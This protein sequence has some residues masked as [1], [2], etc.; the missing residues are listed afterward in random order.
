MKTNSNIVQKVK[1]TGDFG[2]FSRHKR[3]ISRALFKKHPKYTYRIEDMSSQQIKDANGFSP[4]NTNSE[5][6]LLEHVNGQDL[7]NSNHNTRRVDG[8]LN[9]NYVSTASAKAFIYSGEF[10]GLMT[11]DRYIY[12][13]S[14]EDGNF[15]DVLDYLDK[16]GSNDALRTRR[17]YRSQREWASKGAI[18]YDKIIS[19]IDKQQLIEFLTRTVG[20]QETVKN[21]EDVEK[22]FDS[23]SQPMP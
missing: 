13:I 5:S 2:F 20:S 14:T 23:L 3:I 12:K 19:Y 8:A 21:E 15:I 6:T 10:G 17:N 22:V 7:N 16:D 18:P 11:G 4:R 9:T 1:D